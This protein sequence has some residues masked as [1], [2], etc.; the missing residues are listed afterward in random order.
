MDVDLANLPP[1]PAHITQVPD[2]I[3]E[4]FDS[5]L[6]WLQKYERAITGG[7]LQPPIMIRAC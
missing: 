4:D 7:T 5:T 1:I 2:E 6:A 3:F